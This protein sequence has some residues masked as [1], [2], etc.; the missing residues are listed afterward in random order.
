MNSERA[1][2][3]LGVAQTAGKKTRRRDRQERALDVAPRG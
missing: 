2:D 1:Q 3:T